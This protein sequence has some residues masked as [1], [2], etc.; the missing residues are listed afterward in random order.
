MGIG[1]YQALGFPCREAA[2]LKFIQLQNARGTS[3]SLM[4]SAFARILKHCVA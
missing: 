4:T 1:E 2:L 3:I